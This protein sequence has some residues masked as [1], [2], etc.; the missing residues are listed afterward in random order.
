MLISKSEAERIA[1]DH[2]G[3]I[4]RFCLFRLNN[5]DDAADMT[6]EVFLLFQQKAD[7]LN[8][9]NIRSWLIS[10]AEKKIYRAYRNK[11]KEA[12]ISYIEELPPESE[13]LM[14]ELDEMNIV[15]DEEI[16]AAKTHLLSK[17]SPEE[18]KLFKLIY[19][20][21]LKYREIAALYGVSEKTINLRAFRLRSKILKMTRVAFILLLILITNARK[22]L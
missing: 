9:V 5:P 3:Y 16:E 10:T 11:T 15:S 7:G 1:A 14:S 6:Q 8:D 2:Y 22:L 13:A 4:Y 17:L 18:Q 20:D 12:N 19:Q 21:K